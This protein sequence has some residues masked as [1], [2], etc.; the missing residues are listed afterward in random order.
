M[1]S[2]RSLGVLALAVSTHAAAVNCPSPDNLVANCGFDVDTAGYVAQDG[3]AIAHDA[4]LGSTSPGAMIVV[5]TTDDANTQAEAELCIDLSA[6]THYRIGADV[7]GTGASQCFLGW[8]EYTQPG[9]TQTSGIF[10]PT[11]TVP[12]NGN[13]FTTLDALLRTSPGVQSVEMVIVCDGSDNM[14]AVFVVDDVYVL[15]GPMFIDGFESD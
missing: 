9:C 1:R 3:D 2:F 8:D 4:Q 7:L 13:G 6:Q 5:D 12:V 15:R 14:P 10:L 11:P